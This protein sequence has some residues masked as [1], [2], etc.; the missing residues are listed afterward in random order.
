MFFPSLA[1][2]PETLPPSSPLPLSLTQS[3]TWREANVKGD[4]PCARSGHTI[5]VVGQK[6][7]LYG[8]VGRKDNKPQSFSDV[9]YVEVNQEE[10]EIK[11]QLAK[12]AAD[13]SPAPRSKHTAIAV[14]LRLRSRT[15]PLPSL[16]SH[17]FAF[18]SI[19]IHLFLHN[20][21]IDSSFLDCLKLTAGCQAHAHLRRCRPQDAL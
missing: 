11:W 20:S 15:F 1:S 17:S 19:Y 12:T 14:S 10:G 16:F 4:M 18:N 6:T 8:G 2:L 21:L 5:T 7:V 13:H 9:Y 3:I